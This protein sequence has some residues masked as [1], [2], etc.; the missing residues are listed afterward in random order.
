MRPHTVIHPSVYCA[1]RVTILYCIWVCVLEIALSANDALYRCTCLVVKVR[2]CKCL[3]LAS[4]MTVKLQ[5]LRNW[6]T[7]AILFKVSDWFIWGYPPMGCTISLSRGS[8][9]YSNE[10]LSTITHRLARTHIIQT[11][12]INSRSIHHHP[13]PSLSS[14]YNI[15]TE[16]YW[17][18]KRTFNNQPMHRRCYWHTRGHC[19]WWY[20]VKILNVSKEL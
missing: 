13:L 3:H 1:Q 9:T 4:L 17:Q 14:P 2:Q 11:W 8:W 16:R 15:I 5:K 20:K 18:D 7:I 6:R 19:N 10:T 12:P